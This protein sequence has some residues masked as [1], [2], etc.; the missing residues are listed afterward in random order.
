MPIWAIS[1]H[2]QSAFLVPI[3][4][5]STFQKKKNLEEVRDIFYLLFELSQ[6]GIRFNS[7]IK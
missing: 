1:P 3:D 4:H 7:K 5:F 6:A 2:S